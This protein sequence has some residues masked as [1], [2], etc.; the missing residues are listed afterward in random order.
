MRRCVCCYEM[1]RAI[2]YVA[3]MRRRGTLVARPLW[4]TPLAAGIAASEASLAH[5]AALIQ[6]DMLVFAPLLLDVLRPSTFASVLLLPTPSLVWICLS[7][8]TCSFHLIS[9]RTPTRSLLDEIQGSPPS[10]KSPRHPRRSLPP[11]A[12]IP[13]EIAPAVSAC[14]S[15]AATCECT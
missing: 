13:T 5:A 14:P 9:F 6:H 1:P 15:E 11:T 2:Q 10:K 4:Q 3:R 8:L 12:H 7:L